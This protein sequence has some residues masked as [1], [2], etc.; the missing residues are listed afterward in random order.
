MSKLIKENTLNFVKS[1]ELQIGNYKLNKYSKTSE[2]GLPFAIFIYHLFGESKHLI[3]F[4][5]IYK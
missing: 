1:C 5:E 3:K 4:K 2:F